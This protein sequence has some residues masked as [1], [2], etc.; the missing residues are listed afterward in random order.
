MAGRKKIVEKDSDLNPMELSFCYEYIAN[1]FNGKQAAI[2][3][4]YSEKTAEVQA[5][6]LLTRLKVQRKVKELTEKH[7]KTLAIKGED[8]IRELTIMGF[9]N[10]SD[11]V[12]LNPA[13]TTIKTFE[14]M[15][16]N[17]RAIQS[18]EVTPEVIGTKIKFKLYDKK[19][20]LELIGKHL[21]MFTDKVD[22]TSGGEKI[23]GPQIYLPDNGRN[24]TD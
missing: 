20:S 9:S 24:K 23:E 15:G 17:T 21:Q 11:F 10:M 18:I 3:A 14:E 1:K 7:L 19:A 22:L 2:S 8:V 5:S 6:Q 16:E 4:G 13:E 12:N